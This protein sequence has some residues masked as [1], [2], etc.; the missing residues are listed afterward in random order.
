ML[1]RSQAQLVFH[2]FLLSVSSNGF[3]PECLPGSQASET[4]S[5]ARPH[6]HHTAE[7]A[8]SGNRLP[9]HSPR[10]ACMPKSDEC[11]RRDGPATCRRVTCRCIVED[12]TSSIQRKHGNFA[13]A[14]VP[15]HIDC[16]CERQPSCLQ[17]TPA[18]YTLS[19]RS[20]L[21]QCWI[22][23]RLR[24]NSNP[25]RSCSMTWTLRAWALGNSGPSVSGARK[26]EGRSGSGSRA[27]S[28]TG[29]PMSKRSGTPPII[30]ALW[31]R[32]RGNRES[33]LAPPSLAS[34][35]LRKTKN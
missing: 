2:Y 10:L 29:S 25:Q 15:A 7:T 19:R 26:A 20:C 17:P 8:Q 3:G 16:R 14:F 11:R 27:A 18:T 35:L 22:Q 5:N 13:K 24:A 1:K 21:L 4:E 32:C 30:H 33:K 28:N 9:R 23:W 12:L 31:K 6:Q 34:I